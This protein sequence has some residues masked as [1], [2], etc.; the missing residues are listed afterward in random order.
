MA[1]STGTRKDIDAA[2]QDLSPSRPPATTP[3]G[4]EQQ[5]IALAME[6]TEKRTCVS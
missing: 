1:R 3:E 4:R 5:L 2:R 6:A